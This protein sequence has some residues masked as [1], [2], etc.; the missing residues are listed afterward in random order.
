MFKIVSRLV[1]SIQA[2]NMFNSRCFLIL[3]LIRIVFNLNHFQLPLFVLSK[4]TVTCLR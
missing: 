3:L 2:Y 1:L 4:V